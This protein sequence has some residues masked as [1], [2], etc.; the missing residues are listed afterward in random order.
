MRGFSFSPSWDRPRQSATLRSEWSRLDWAPTQRLRIACVT[1]QCAIASVLAARKT[2][3]GALTLDGTG[4]SDPDETITSYD[5]SE[6]G[7]VR[8]VSLGFG[9]V[10]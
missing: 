9:S 5:W 8:W 6:G 3:I 7:S 4:S 2:W 1:V 10:P